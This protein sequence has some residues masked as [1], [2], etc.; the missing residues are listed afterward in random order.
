[1]ISG[2]MSVEDI[3]NRYPDAIRFF[4]ERGIICI[5]CGEPVWGTLDDLLSRNGILLFIKS[6]DNYF[7]ILTSISD[8]NPNP[9]CLYIVILDYCH[10]IFWHDDSNRL[11]I[12]TIEPQPRCQVCHY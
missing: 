9:Y 11:D 8:G 5:Q 12:L 10:K 1:M 2:G 6:L 7:F 4:M 3:V